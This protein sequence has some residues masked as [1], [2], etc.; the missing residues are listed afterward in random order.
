[1]RGLI[2]FGL[3]VALGGAVAAAAADLRL[4]ER[5]SLAHGSHDIGGGMTVAA[6]LRPI[7]DGGTALCG[8]WAE[9]TDLAAVT[10]GA[11]RETLALAYV[12]V[13][14]RR[15]ARDLRFMPKIAPRLDYAGAPARCRAIDL[16]WRA[17]R[18]PEVFLP[19]RVIRPANRDTGG[20][21][22]T[23]SPTGMGAMSGALDPV[24]VLRRQIGTVPLSPRA[25][26]AEGHY[27]SGGG[28]RLAVELVAKNG[29]AALCG[30]WSD[31]P[32][33]VART[34]PLGRAVLRE[35]V[36]M[37]GQERLAVDAGGFRRV[38]AR[39]DYT[40]ATANC[41]DTGL[42][43]TPGRDRAPLRIIL[44]ARV[45]YRT[46]T[47]QGTQIIRFAPRD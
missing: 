25:R 31:L 45:V 20:N 19:R 6:E 7:A 28:L 44:P 39:A 37:L 30:A 29:Q 40:G 26:V 42:G 16:P 32:G 33:Q 12:H 23:F 43:W 14:G 21:Q 34:E 41:L 8:A 1:M 35:A 11:A 22:V 4:G 15:V 13:E 47:T 17:G 3:A 2:L 38:P 36:I 27:S 10:V 24:A 9:S 18:V 5:V 46:T